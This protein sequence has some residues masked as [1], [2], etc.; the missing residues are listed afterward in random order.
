MTAVNYRIIIDLLSGIMLVTGVFMLGRVRVRSL[1]RLFAIQSL[2]LALIAG[3][4]AVFESKWHLLV[5]AI[6]V[7]A[8]KTVFLPIFMMTVMTRGRVLERLVS[9]MR[10]ALS[11]FVGV[12]MAV[13]GFYLTTSLIPTLGDNFFVV[14]VSISLA[15]IGLLMLMTRK[16]LYGQIVGFLILENGIFTLGLALTGGMPLLVEVGV[17]FDVTVGAILMALLSYR[18]SGESR[19]ADTEYLET[20]ID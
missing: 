7:F 19:R 10:P 8:I 20:L 9:T 12:I 17:F 11:M 18:V 13:L 5:T 2:A 4:S 3:S 6:L 1:L 14:A 15:L 16:G